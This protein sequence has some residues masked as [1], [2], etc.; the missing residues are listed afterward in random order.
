MEAR[1]AQQEAEAAAAG[2]EEAPVDE[3]EGDELDNSVAATQ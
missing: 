3:T 1:R 2:T